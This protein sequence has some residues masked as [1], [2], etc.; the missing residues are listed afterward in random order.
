M[1]PNEPLVPAEEVLPVGHVVQ[2]LACVKLYL[3]AGQF[4]HAVAELVAAALCLPAVHDAQF[5]DETR[6]VP[7]SQA[8]HAPVLRVLVM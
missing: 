3:P 1:V 6:W 5:V 7:G 8:V 4:V 2:L